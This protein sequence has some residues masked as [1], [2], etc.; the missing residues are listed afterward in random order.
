ML[1]TRL[2]WVA[3]RVV[4][5][6]RAQFPSAVASV[7]KAR[8]AITAFARQWFG[9]EDLSDIESAAG[10][11]LANC[12]EH[13]HCQGQHIDVRCYFD[14]EKLSIEIRDAGTGFD[15]PNVALTPPSD[16]PRGFG[17]SIMRR[18]MDE[19]EYSERGTRLRLIKRLPQERCAESTERARFG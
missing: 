6:Y 14:S 16:A 9:G 11:A 3:E 7:G 10:E 4:A 15:Y 19:V 1:D 5:E 12:A 13:G 2:R 8:R 18:L 17:T